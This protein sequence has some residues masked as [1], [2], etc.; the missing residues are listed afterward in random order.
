[1][2]SGA[3]TGTA[4]WRPTGSAGP[5]IWVHGD[6]AS[7]DG[8]GYW[9]IHGRSDDTI[10]IAGRRVG[11][12]EIEA[13]LVTLP[14]VAEAAVIGVPDAEKGSRIVAFVTLRQLPVCWRKRMRSRR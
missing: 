11:P 9:R 6:L 4:T 7:V 8:D 12:A 13:A 5:S 10:K 1:M 2:G 3:V 14:A